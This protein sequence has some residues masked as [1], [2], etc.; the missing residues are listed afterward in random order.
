MQ[1]TPITACQEDSWECFFQG[2]FGVEG[3]FEDSFC[4]FLHSVSFTLK[5][6]TK[7]NKMW[8]S[9]CTGSSQYRDCC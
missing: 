4:S 9:E 8:R 3:K 5:N 2:K 7:S 1:I 6:L